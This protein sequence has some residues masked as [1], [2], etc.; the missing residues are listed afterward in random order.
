[1]ETAYHR[2]KRPERVRRALLDQAARLALEQGLAAVTVQAVCDAAGVT[3]GT[4]FDHFAGK[5]ALIDAVVAGLL[6]KLDADIAAA[7]AE[8]TRSQGR[9]TRAYV[10]VTLNDLLVNQTSQW[11]ALYISSLTEP[12]LR[13]VTAEWFA[14]SVD[15][16]RATDDHPTLE[17]ARLAA[18]GAW[19]AG[20]LLQDGAPMPDLASLRDRLVA[21]TLP[22]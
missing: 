8:D 19:L 2:R 21:M 1:M 15:R 18:D 14:T 9:F 20:L 7:M 17:V 4:L 5:P 6:A 11:T 22:D 3:K 13:R 10:T 12:S 16:H